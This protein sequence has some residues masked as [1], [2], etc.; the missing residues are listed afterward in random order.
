MT[1]KYVSD[2]QR[3]M[4]LVFAMEEV[5]NGDKLVIMICER[6]YSASRKNYIQIIELD[7][8]NGINANLLQVLCPS[9]SYDNPFA[10]PVVR[11]AVATVAL[12]PY[13]DAQLVLDWKAQSAFVIKSS[14]P[15]TTTMELIPAYLILQTFDSVDGGIYMYLISAQDALRA[16]GVPLDGDTAFNSV[17]VNQLPKILAQ[18]VVIPESKPPFR[19]DQQL[20]VHARP[21]HRDAY[22][23]WVYSAA[24]ALLCS[25][26][27]ALTP[28]PVWRERTRTTPRTEVYYQEIAYSGHAQSFERVAKRGVVHQILPPIIPVPLTRGEL[29][30]RGAAD[31]IDVSAYSGALTFATNSDV[32]VL[33]LAYGL[34][35][36]S[37]GFYQ[38]LSRGGKRKKREKGGRL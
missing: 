33:Y 23:I 11:G 30:L 13:S 2:L 18:E 4:V 28:T 19:A 38:V 34:C 8:R 16:H 21:L 26:D 1:W 7:P 6:T 25:Y 36:L 12:S 35:L 3:S 17:T 9:T 32:V 37:R 10:A 20:C 14:E 31:P 22:R 15:H 24:A 5:V 27:L 29:D